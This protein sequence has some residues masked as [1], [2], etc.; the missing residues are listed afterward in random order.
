HYG[1]SIV[2]FKVELEGKIA[3]E[4]TQRLLSKLDKGDIIFLLSTIQSR[5]EGN[6]IYLRIDKQALISQGRVLLK[7]GDDVIKIVISLKD[8]I[9]QFMEELKRLASG[10]LYT[11]S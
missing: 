6:R 5:S 10:N 7:D 9:K 8:N 4:V 3:G 1:D 11:R 2:T